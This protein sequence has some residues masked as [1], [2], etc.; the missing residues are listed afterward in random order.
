M[1]LARAGRS[2][3]QVAD[4]HG[5]TPAQ[6]RSGLAPPS[7]SGGVPDPRYFHVEHL[8][9]NVAAGDLAL[10]AQDLAELG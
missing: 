6:I 10:S 8:E 9:E 2:L 4:R 7:L 5:A 1:H 3:D